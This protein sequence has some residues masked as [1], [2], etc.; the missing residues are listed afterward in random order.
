MKKNL[1][2]ENK[3]RYFQIEERVISVYFRDTEKIKLQ[4]ENVIS[5]KEVH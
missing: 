5:N 1:N 4:R 3:I 2:R